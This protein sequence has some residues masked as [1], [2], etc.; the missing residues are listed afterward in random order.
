MKWIR[1]WF[2]K[3]QP[4][5]P[6][7]PQPQWTIGIYGGSSPLDLQDP[8]PGLNPVI[9]PA[10]IH[11]HACTLVA[12]PFMF[13][14][15]GVWHLFFE[16]EVETSE[17]L[18]GK[19][20]HALSQ[21]GKAWEYQGMVL[22]EPFHLSYPYVF[23]HGGEI[24]MIPETRSQRSIRIYRAQPFPG[25]WRLEKTLMK[26]RRFADNSLF[27]FEGRWWMFSDSGNHTRRLYHADQPLGPWKEHKK[28]PLIKKNPS[29]ARPGGR[30]VLVD[31]KPV[32]FA[33]D[34][35]PSY[36][37]RVLAF[38]ITQLTPTTYAETPVEIPHVAASGRGWNQEGM[39]TVDAH[40]LGDGRWLACV[41]GL[42]FAEENHG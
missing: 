30:V 20:G 29:T 42:G 9:T 34:G 23:A 8:E 38:E 28:S 15:E 35:V 14:R 16:A 18:R 36:G 13:R 7:G 10:H 6:Q 27:E 12:D 33:Q 25:C 31:G 21:D 1:N 2:K 39:H 11:D 17:G 32:R 3:P 26:G 22:E 40:D 37:R 24:Y 41:D 4:E 5:E 19:I